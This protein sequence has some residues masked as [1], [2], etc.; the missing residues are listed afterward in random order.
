M[1]IRTMGKF[2]PHRPMKFCH[3]SS[4][5]ALT[6]L[7][8]QN[9]LQHEP[10]PSAHRAE[11]NSAVTNI[12]SMNLAYDA[13]RSSQ[14]TPRL[15]R[16][17]QPSMLSKR[18]GAPYVLARPRPKLF[19]QSKGFVVWGFRNNRARLSFCRSAAVPNMNSL[20]IDWGCPHRRIQHLF[21]LYI[22]VACWDLEPIYLQGS[23]PLLVSARFKIGIP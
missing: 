13:C 6:C 20:L 22:A 7:T 18:S 3:R 4:G 19:R 17:L 2:S 1:V 11:D 15:H 8:L 14:T 23:F 10:Q 12:N 9:Q 16:I 5:A 21:F